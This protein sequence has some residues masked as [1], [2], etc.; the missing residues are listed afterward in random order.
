MD[1]KTFIEKYDKPDIVILLLGKRKVLKEDEQKITELGIKLAKQT[2]H[3]KFSAKVDFL[4]SLCKKTP[5]TALC[6]FIFPVIYIGK[7]V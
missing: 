4:V 7:L 2:Q 3:I 5:N 1:F 6:L